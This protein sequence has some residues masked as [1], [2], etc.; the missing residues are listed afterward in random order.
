MSSPQRRREKEKLP[1]FNGFISILISAGFSFALA[2]T[3]NAAI[4]EDEKIIPMIRRDETP[5]IYMT[6]MDTKVDDKI[7]MPL[8]GTVWDKGDPNR[9]HIPESLHPHC[10]CFWVDA[11]SGQNLGQF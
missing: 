10:R 1:P 5:I 7:C 8:E 11:I 2:T 4:Q 9:P 3:I 6:Q